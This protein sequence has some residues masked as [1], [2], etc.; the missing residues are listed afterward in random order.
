MDMENEKQIFLDIWIGYSRVLRAVDTF[1]LT[2]IKR[3]VIFIRLI[4]FNESK[5]LLFR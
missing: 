4:V 3:N 5:G 1:W 2:I